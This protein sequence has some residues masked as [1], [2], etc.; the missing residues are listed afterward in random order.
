MKTAIIAL[1]GVGWWLAASQSLADF[2][3]NPRLGLLADNGERAARGEIGT[4]GRPASWTVTPDSVDPINTNWASLD[5]PP[6]L[7]LDPYPQPESITTATGAPQAGSMSTDSE[8]GRTSD[9]GAS[10]ILI[11]LGG[12][13]L[14]SL[15]WRMT[16]SSPSEAIS[17]K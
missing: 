3:P 7:D 4:L 5:S 9:V 13:V 8:V 11:A 16:R 10:F 14:I 15:R 17:A 2:R 1:L 6:S 12:G